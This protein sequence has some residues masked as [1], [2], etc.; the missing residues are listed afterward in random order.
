MPHLVVRYPPRTAPLTVA[1]MRPVV[2]TAPISSRENPRSTQKGRVIGSIAASPSL[3]SRA[4]ERTHPMPGRVSSERSG[5]HSDW[6]AGGRTC[7][8][9]GRKS[10]AAAS[11]AVTT[12]A[13]VNAAGHPCRP[14]SQINAPPDTSIAA[15]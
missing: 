10:A 12:V 4:N 14:A 13:V 11:K 3:K 8:V 15:R 5:S 7:P 2:S 9:S 1:I 6:P